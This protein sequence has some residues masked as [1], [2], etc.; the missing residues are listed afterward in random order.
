PA[1][2]NACPV[3]ERRYAFR[4]L[5]FGL[6]EGRGKMRRKICA[7]AGC[8]ALLLAGLA[9]WGSP[10]VVARR[11]GARL[12]SEAVGSADVRTLEGLHPS[13]TLLF[14]GWGVT[15]AG[16]HVRLEGDMPLKMVLSPDGR[17]LAASLG[18]F[19]HT[20]LALIDVAGRRAAQFIPMLRA[21]NGLAFSKEGDHL[22]VSG[23]NSGLLHAFPMEGGKSGA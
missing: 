14:N 3:L 15:P 9:W 8:G 16:Q 7:A 20:G 5:G 4:A 11:G 12:A 22:F 13:D 2:T 1:P 17:T 21:W 10:R 19:S 6:W 23:G 18:G